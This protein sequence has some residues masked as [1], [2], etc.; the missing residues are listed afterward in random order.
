MKKVNTHHKLQL[1]LET[2]KALA[3]RQLK[4]VAGGGAAVNPQVIHPTT[5]AQSYIC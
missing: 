5:T 3:E 2:V 1:K 4:D